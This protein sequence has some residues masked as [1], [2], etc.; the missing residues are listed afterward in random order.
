[1]S[2][3]RLFMTRRRPLANLTKKLEQYWWKQSLLGK[4]QEKLSREKLE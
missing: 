1:M 2:S 3:R 4:D